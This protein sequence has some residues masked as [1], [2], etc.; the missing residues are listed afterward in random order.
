MKDVRQS[1][2]LGRMAVA[3]H[4]SVER[5]HVIHPYQYF[6]ATKDITEGH[7]RSDDRK[8]FTLINLLLLTSAKAVHPQKDYFLH[9]SDTHVAGA[10]K[11]LG[12]HDTEPLATTLTIL[13]VRVDN[14]APA[15]GSPELQPERGQTLI[16]KEQTKGII[17]KRVQKHSVMDASSG[18]HN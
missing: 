5:R 1:H 10:G 18:V 14:Q 3:I 16:L 17:I 8:E 11:G 12:D 2:H 15:R 13:S 6:A 7:D 9:L 4:G